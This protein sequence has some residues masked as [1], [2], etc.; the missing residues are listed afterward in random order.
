M[1]VTLARHLGESLGE[2]LTPAV[3]FDY[4]TVDA[5][6]DHLATILPELDEPD[7]GAMRDDYEQLTED[8]LLNQLSERLG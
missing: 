7:G 2:A 5:L 1:S 8:E 3:V 6:A 4:P